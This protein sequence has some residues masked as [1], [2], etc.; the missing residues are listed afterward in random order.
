MC[1]AEYMSMQGIHLANI[2]SERPMYAW[3][4]KQVLHFLPA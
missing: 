3:E 4:K 1:K 2:L